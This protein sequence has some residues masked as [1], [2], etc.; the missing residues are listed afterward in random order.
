[1]ALDLMEA[2]QTIESPHAIRRAPVAPSHALAA[3]ARPLP[4][5]EQLRK[6]I[7]RLF[8]VTNG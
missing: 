5:Q 6:K 4:T 8:P 2:G 3:P 1:M 7:E